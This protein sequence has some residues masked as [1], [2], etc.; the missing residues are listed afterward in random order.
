MSVFD[1]LNDGPKA[2]IASKGRS[3]VMHQMRIDRNSFLFVND[4]THIRHDKN[5]VKSK[6]KD[7]EIRKW[8]VTLN[9]VFNPI[10]QTSSFDTTNKFID[11]QLQNG[12]NT[13]YDY[14]VTQMFRIFTK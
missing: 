8:A 14:I 6:D 1:N 2:G 13:H 11:E 3:R 12:M 5:P 7:T 4:M 9:H 10:I